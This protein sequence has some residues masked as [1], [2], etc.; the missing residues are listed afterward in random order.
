[1]L[2]AGGVAVRRARE[3]QR[4]HRPAFASRAGY[5][6]D[7]RA[8]P[9]RRRRR[10]TTSIPAARSSAMPAPGDARVGV[11][12][13]ADDAGDAGGDQR[14]GAGR[15]PAVMRAGLQ[16]HVDGRAARERARPRRAPASR[17]AAGRPARST[18]APTTRP[19]RTISA[20]TLGLGAVSPRLRRPSASAGGHEARVVAHFGT[21][22]GSRLQLADDGVEVARLAEIAVDRGETHIGDAVER[23]Q[24]L[25]HQFA[26]AVGRDVGVALR[27]R[28]GARR[29]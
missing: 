18:P 28:A 2:V 3:L 17:R 6:R 7:G 8:A 26:D 22:S 14:L 12:Q 27:S 23:L 16:R 25:H 15:R 29:R 24:P 21:V 4:H 9:P 5:G 10:A 11:L 19:S 20:P 13:R 1:M